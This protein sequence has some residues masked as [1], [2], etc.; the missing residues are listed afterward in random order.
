MDNSPLAAKRRRT[1]SPDGSEDDEPPAFVYTGQPEKE[2]PKNIT[3]VAFDPSVQAIGDWAFTNCK[4]L[5]SIDIPATTTVKTIGVEAFSGCDSLVN[6]RLHT[7]LRSIGRSG[8]LECRALLEIELNHGLESIGAGAFEECE[9]LRTISI[10]LTVETI[11][12]DVFQD[13][14]S[15]T[16]VSFHNESMMQSIGRRAFCRCESL[17]HIDLPR[18]LRMISFCAFAGCDNL[19]TALIPDTVEIIDASAFDSCRGLVKVH[20]CQGL[21]SIGARAFARCISLG[22]IALPS[23][24]EVVNSHAFKDCTG[25]LGVEIPTGTKITIRKCC[26]EDC[27]SLINVS[28]PNSDEN[29]V[30][31]TAFSGCKLLVDLYRHDD[32]T[33]DPIASLR[34][35]FANLPVHNACY[36]ASMT[37]V[38]KLTQIINESTNLM[39]GEN[40]AD[41]FGLSPLH[42]AA[43]SANLREDLFECLLERY[44]VE[45]LWHCDNYGKTATDYLLA[46]TSEKAVPLIQVALQRSILDTMSSWGLPKW[47]T[48]LDLHTT[49]IPSDNDTKARNAHVHGIFQ[50]LGSCTRVEVTSLIEQALWKM[51]MSGELREDDDSETDEMYRENCRLQCGSQIV[52]E[53]VIEYLWHCE[54]RSDTALSMF[55]LCN[56]WK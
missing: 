50:Y 26:F 41:A 43:T 45:V 19:K 37:S 13:C 10:P 53:N 22:A 39:E 7:G 15:L 24:I 34:E 1:A 4:L 47:R 48:E 18:G 54:S 56:N 23:T 20:L 29:H 33:I 16:S 28:V 2:I 51:R 52:I 36:N 25:L 42:V 3:H 12:D 8:F 32:E 44:P 21:V 6:V 55:P 35:R 5:Q 9:S 17:Q 11:G 30:S 27:T 31:N 46:H 49:S 14:V 40:V 38:D